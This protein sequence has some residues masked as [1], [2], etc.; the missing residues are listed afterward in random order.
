MAIT[1][2]PFWGAFAVL[3]CALVG[4]APAMALALH[5]ARFVLGRL[6][7]RR[8]ARPVRASG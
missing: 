6:W 7:A 4:F 3:V 1:P 5:G 8:R 2:D